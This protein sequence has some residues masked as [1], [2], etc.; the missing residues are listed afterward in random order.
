MCLGWRPVPFRFISSLSSRLGPLERNTTQRN[1]TLLHRALYLLSRGVAELT[2]NNNVVDRKGQGDYF[3]A[4]S[5]LAENVKAVYG[6][7]AKTYC[8]FFVLRIKKF[9]EIVS[10]YLTKEEI[11]HLTTMAQKKYT[12]DQKASKFFTG[13]HVERPINWPFTHL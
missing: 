6:L 11:E 12:S 2:K 1:A 3:Q 7:R 8:E 13:G 9:D 4:A 5:L 10:Q